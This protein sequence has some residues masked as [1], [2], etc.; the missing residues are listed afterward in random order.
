MEQ[1]EYRVMAAAEDGHWWYPATRALLQA[2]AAPAL[3]PGGRFLDAGCGTGA[4]G[5]WL[6]DVG[7]VVGLDFEPL[8][9]EL[10][11]ERHPETRL[12]AGDV[13]RLPVADGA[14]DGLLCV[15]VLVH[16]SVTDVGAA[17]RELV[18]VVRPGGTVVLLEAGVRR[19]RRA[20]D[21]ETHSARRF[22]RRELAGH[23]AA[24]GCTIRR[25]TGAYSFLVPPAAVKSVLER[26]TTASDLA[27]AE[28]GMGGVL[29]K[30][31]AVERRWLARHDLPFGLSVIAVGDKRPG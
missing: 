9:L 4:A 14:F 6:H 31:A 27:R 15:T 30:L 11:A 13:T 21:R 1:Q 7:A 5:S 17:V 22:S 8:A 23:L 19:L 18:R 24:A 12:V 10:Y 3:A 2:V 20:H 25:S 16:Q 29:P 28:T 26:G